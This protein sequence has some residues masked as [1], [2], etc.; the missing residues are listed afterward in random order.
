MPPSAPL[1]SERTAHIG[2][3][4]L[5]SSIVRLLAVT[6]L[7]GAFAP[8]VLANVTQRYLKFDGTDDHVAIAG[9]A[10]LALTNQV[11]VEAWI[12]PEA[13]SSTKA[14]NRIVTKDSSLELTISTGDTGCSFNSTGHVQWRATIAGV[15]RRICGGT[16]TP[17]RWTHVAGTY[18]GS[19][20]S[21]YVDGLRVAT[22]SRAGPLNPSTK[23]LFIGNAHTLTTG[24][25][26]AVDEVRVWNLARTQDQILAAKNSELD[27]T[28][29]GLLAYYTL[30]EGTGQLA[31]DFSANALHGQLGTTPDADSA[32]PVWDPAGPTVNPRLA[33]FEDATAR[34]GPLRTEL[35]WG[36]TWADIN[37]DDWPD[38]FL[39]NHYRRP[40][41]LLLNNSGEFF[42]NVAVEAG[43]GTKTD[44]HSCKWADFDRDGD[45]DV[46]CI[47]GADHG[48]RSIPA[49]FWRNRGDGIFTDIAASTG[50]DFPTARGRTVSWL[51]VDRDGD[52]DLFIGTEIKTTADPVSRLYRNDGETFTDIT[53]QAGIALN[54]LVR[55]SLATDIDGDGDSDLLVSFHERLGVPGPCAACVLLLRNDGSG[56]FS[57]S[58]AGAIGLNIGFPLAIAI[59]DYDNDEDLDVFS[60]GE[61]APKLH[62]NNG[63]GSFTRIALAGVGL[64]DVA[65]F[66]IEDVQWADFDND[67]FLDLYVVRN[68]ADGV[69]NAPNLLMRNNGNRTFSDATA[70]FEA[71]GFEDGRGDAAAVADFDRN[72]FLDLLVANGQFETEGR[73]QLLMNAGNTNHWLRVMPIDSQG[74]AAFG[75]KVSAVSGDLAQFR[76]YGDTS[77]HATSSESV[78]HFGLGSRN[79]VDRVRIQWPDGSASEVTNLPVNRSVRVEQANP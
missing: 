45:W 31:T 52:L 11:T 19:K 33:A 42:T 43:L 18:D 57:T 3:C 6:V 35:S 62:R 53:L 70:Q 17:G 41:Y 16:L 26:G 23:P 64:G 74:S 76:E 44:Y 5:E 21:L 29:L 28:E 75:A 15:N 12:N 22:A 25:R 68:S 65:A 7:V 10:S 27:G 46:F 63:N 71:A 36:A 73:Y 66:P 59:G 55:I 77:D 72:G 37:G 58:N 50:T 54:G 67:G 14:Q 38:A 40:P 69:T 49:R 9:A 34:L 32:D 8:A 1:V 39:N 20:F 2:T 56:V 4:N 61:I 24:I 79:I 51:D 78:L 30:N 60:G 47:T 48:T 13:I